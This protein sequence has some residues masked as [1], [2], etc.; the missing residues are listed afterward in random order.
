MRKLFIYNDMEISQKTYY[1]KKAGNATVY[2][3]YYS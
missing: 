1:V 3:T 2:I